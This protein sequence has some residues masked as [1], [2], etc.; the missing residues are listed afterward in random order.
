MVMNGSLASSAQDCP[1]TRQDGRGKWAPFP[2]PSVVEFLQGR[3]L[4]LLLQMER[5]YDGNSSYLFARSKMFCVDF[6]FLEIC[7]VV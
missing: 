2:K 4:L 7:Q 3:A 6:K 5:Y 1:I